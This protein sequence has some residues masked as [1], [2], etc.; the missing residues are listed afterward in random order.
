LDL[1]GGLKVNRFLWPAL[2]LVLLLAACISAIIFLDVSNTRVDN[3]INLALTAVATCASVAGAA[4][5]VLGKNERKKSAEEP[6]SVPYS[7][8]TPP[9]SVSTIERD[10]ESSLTTY[11][12]NMRR[13]LVDLGINQ[14]SFVTLTTVADPTDHTD[15]SASGQAARSELLPKLEWLNR[16]K[17]TEFLNAEPETVDLF[18]I[19][20]QFDQTVLLGEPGS[21]KSTLLQRLALEELDR[22]ESSRKS[23]QANSGKGESAAFRLPLYAS[24]SDWQPGVRAVEFLRSQLQN[25]VGPE[26]YYM[27]H[28]ES[29]LNDGLFIFLLDG[30]NELPGRKSNS[31]EGRHELGT[32]T[33]DN[34]RSMR[35]GAASFDRRE[36]DLREFA[37]S[38]GLQSKFVLTCR[39]HEYFDSRRWQVIRVLPM[40]VEQIDRFIG[41]YVDADRANELRV[42]LRQDQ[43]LASI[44]D[45]PFFLRIIIRIYQPGM[46]PSS[47]G[48]I[49]SK[50]YQIL[51]EDSQRKGATADLPSESRITESMGRVSFRMLAAGEVGSQAPLG[52][53][54]DDARA[55]A[56]V[57]AA[58]GL[59]VERD[60]AFRFV[61]Q[62]IQEFFAARALH[63]RAVKRSHKTLLA[64][65]RWSEVVALWCDLDKNRMPDRIRSALR[66]RNLPW[67]RPRSRPTPLLSCYQLITTFGI[68][69]VAAMYFWSWALWPIHTLSFPFFQ[70]GYSPIVI[71]AVA[72]AVRVVWVL[73]IKHRKIIVNSSYVLSTIRYP[74]ALGNIVSSFS[75]LYED[76]RAEVATYVARSFGLIALP[77]L[78]RGV[79][80]PSWRIR[81]GCV[82]S[83]GEIA[84]AY[85][86][87]RRP[88]DTLL[89]LAT[90][91]DPQLMKALVQAFGGCQDERIPHAVGE[92][93]S[94]T[95]ASGFALP[96]RLAPLSEW[97]I[98]TAANWHEDAVAR[99][100]ELARTGRPPVLRAAVLQ[101][102]GRLQFPN[103]ESLLA[104]VAA[105]AS[106]P[107]FVR[108]SAIKGLGLAETSEAVEHLVELGEQNE[109]LTKWV[110][111]SLRG[112]KDPA[113]MSALVRAAR[114]PKWEIRQ[115]A[116]T[117]LGR[118][119]ASEA[120]EAL[121]E[122][123]G[124]KNTD[125]REAA[126]R[127]LSMIDVSAAVPVLGRL[128]QDPD[129]QVRKTALE[130]LTSRY[131]HLAGSELLGLAKEADYPDRVR[132]IRSLGRY[133]RPE[134]E[135]ELRNLTGDVDKNVRDAA[136]LALQRIYMTGSP[137]RKRVNSKVSLF[138]GAWQRLVVKLQIDGY[139]DML[140][141]ERLVGTP[142]YQAGSKVT[143]KIFA[144]AELTRRYRPLFNFIL[145]GLTALCVLGTFLLVLILG[146]SLWG[147]QNLLGNWIW[148][149]G[150][151]VI[152]LA[153]ASYLPGVRRL[154]DV[155]GV[156]AIVLLLWMGASAA[157]IIGLLGAIAYVWWIL[158]LSAVT[159]GL[160]A[161][162]VNMHNRR[163][164]RRQ[165]RAA[166]ATAHEA[167]AKAA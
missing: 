117:A 155:R 108:Q 149:Y 57:L 118:T 42:A 35:M 58:T 46:Q 22:L 68:M 44:S 128:A 99:F 74:A 80:Q 34:L 21:G 69:V 152:V 20:D 43:K 139:R 125:V 45:N 65:K 163:S 151:G 150:L 164:R 2:G 135:D 106:E 104:G 158:L 144:D 162:L 154:R 37:S 145:V 81:A 131:P 18:N 51:L 77:H 7:S 166:L 36:I 16:Q 132:V 109:K 56:Q 8:A 85:P 50:L 28:F 165:V 39:S 88:M 133:V 73:V 113:T 83:L 82:Q 40:N 23:P 10:Q 122:L 147:A 110:C 167:T 71:L 31:R 137:R 67:R 15:N 126:A 96:Y 112:V 55:C 6:I 160:V 54:E 136:Q 79:Q 159:A 62:I 41:A 93:L 102:M 38:I 92:M 148:I 48:Q 103:S 84:R 161:S 98:H 64:D 76:E 24:L 27:H 130:A 13:R 142:D 138:T 52:E 49:L 5:G 146:L 140:R 1:G 12:R 95:Q 9:I 134:L 32:E 121:A 75:M 17:N 111:G 105:D 90:A 87:D 129:P 100:E 127:G 47:R 26:N 120:F 25:L 157:V 116:A 119:G 30:L 156:G 153:A 97:D 59:V 60:G 141:E 53:L 143:A 86:E 114:S 89:A 33:A 91:R 3:G 19:P 115:V 107:K 4:F 14:Q 63:T 70:A 78:T 123:S 101:M 124:D 66:A 61:H 94:D 11:L 72:L 29:S